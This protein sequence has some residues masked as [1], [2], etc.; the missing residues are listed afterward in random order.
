MAFVLDTFAR[1]VFKRLLGK[2]HTSGTRDPGNEP[3]PSTFT[4]SAQTIW[5]QK[6]HPTP[7]D[8]SNTGIVSDLVTLSL[9][10]VSGTNNTGKYAA[11]RCKLGGT[12]PAS[13]V[14]KVNRKTGAIY[15]ANDYV[16]D[17]IPGQF[18]EDY[19][20]RLFAGAVET[21]PLDASDWFV[22]ASSGIVT[23]EED[24]PA[25]MIE[26]GSTG[27]LQCY[28]YIGQFVAD[29]LS[30]IVAGATQFYDY[31]TVGS[32]ITGTLDGVNNTFTL[33]RTPAAGSVHMFINGVLTRDFSIAGNTLTIGPETTELLDGQNEFFI[34]YRV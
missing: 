12:V 23:Q 21:P 5:A 26:Y 27:T 8:A 31:Q 11:Y 22:D 9:D 4:L 3:F 29:S 28:I 32:G 30:G 1:S 24:S 17:I 15:A 34:H 6:I 20:P 13:L 16:G 19:T 14:G 2:S 33:P 18:G 25:F 10:P 7:S